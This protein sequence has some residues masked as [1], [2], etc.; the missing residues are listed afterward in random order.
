[1]PCIFANPIRAVLFDVDGTLYYQGMLRVCMALELS[2]LPFRRQP[3]QTASEMWR[4]LRIFRHVR[5][6][7]RCCHELPV[8]LEQ[9]Q[10]SAAAKQT[11]WELAQLECL[12]REWMHTRPLKYLRFCKRRGLKAFLVFLQH[13]GRHIGVFSDYP[14]VEKLSRLKCADKMSVTLCATDLEINAFK[15]SPKGFLHACAHWGLSPQ[16]VLYVGDRPDVDAVGAREAGMPC[17]ILSP[18]LQQALRRRETLSY[19][20]VSTFASLQRML[21]SS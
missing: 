18:W 3:E 4:A 16:E 20:H 13:S 19:Y 1:M 7:L 21:T 6:E 10:Y 12:V 8:C 14:V 2:S 5:E 15:P 17:A 9:W 11:D